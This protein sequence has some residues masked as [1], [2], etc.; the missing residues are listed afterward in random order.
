MGFLDD[1]SSLASMAGGLGFPGLGLVGTGGKVV[2]KLAG[3]LSG[4]R[5]APDHER[6]DIKTISNATGLTEK[7]VEDLCGMEEKR[8]PDNYDDIVKKYANSPG[9][10]LSLVNE[11]NDKN[12]SRAIVALDSIPD[13]MPTQ[14][15][16]TVHQSPVASQSFTVPA[17]VYQASTSS[18]P[19]SNSLTGTDLKGLGTAVLTGAQ[20]AATDWAM[21]TPEGQA[22]KKSGMKNWLRENQL[23]VFIAGLG[24]LGLIYKAFFSRK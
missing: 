4:K 2:S 11:W 19:V 22:A 8:S 13:Y 15:A 6:S 3:F 18:A 24:L 5:G 1:A 16:A 14:V 20:N 12:P 9:G 23:G 7:Q 17:S 21:N 10:M